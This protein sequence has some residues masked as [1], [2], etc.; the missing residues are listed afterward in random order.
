MNQTSNL[1]FEELLVVAE[2]AG[3]SLITYAEKDLDANV[4]NCPGWNN[5]ELLN[6]MKGVWWF[7]AAQIVA[8][9]DS[10]RAIPVSYT[11]LTLP[12]KRIV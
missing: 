6:H 11:H 10:E 9:N 7:V 1:E 8:G 5:L 12:T 3:R 2:E 4:P